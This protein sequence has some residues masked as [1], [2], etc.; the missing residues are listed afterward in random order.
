MHFGILV[1]YLE[2]VLV[3]ILLAI[4]AAGVDLAVTRSARSLPWFARTEWAEERTRALT[5][6]AARSRCYA[7]IG[8]AV[9][10]I[11]ALSPVW[12]PAVSESPL[13]SLWVASQNAS[14]AFAFE[15]EVWSDRKRE[16]ASDSRARYDAFGDESRQARLRQ[17]YGA[18]FERWITA[19]GDQ[20]IQVPGE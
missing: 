7:M 8:I 17:A 5:K 20:V 3:A 13:G 12:Q 2:A 16:K 18:A 1:W 9:V 4:R 11:W 6:S 15:V 14:R 10:V 19:V